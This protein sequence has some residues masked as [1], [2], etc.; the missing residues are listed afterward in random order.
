[1]IK[2]YPKI[3]KKP[4]KVKGCKYDPE[5]YPKYD[6]Y[7]AIECSKSVDIPVDYDGVIGVPITILYHFYGGYIN[8]EYDDGFFYWS[9]Q[10]EILAFMTGAKGSC[11]VNGNDGRAKFYINNVGVYARILIRKHV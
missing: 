7:D 3:E 1:M 8:V 4:L 9:K 5:K 2:D 10:F 11:L 6:N